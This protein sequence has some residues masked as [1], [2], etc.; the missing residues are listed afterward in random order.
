MV[1]N[2]STNNGTTTYTKNEIDLLIK[3]AKYSDGELVYTGITW[4]SYNSDGTYS[5]PEDVDYVKLTCTNCSSYVPNY[6]YLN[7]I[8]V[9]KGSVVYSANDSYVKA[10]FSTPGTLR[11]AGYSSAYKNDRA[12]YTAEAYRYF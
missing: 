1:G 2:V 3:G 10:D 7:G 4:V 11:L 5:F 8:K 12:Y 6:Q 9:A